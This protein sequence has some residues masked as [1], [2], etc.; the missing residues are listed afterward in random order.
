MNRVRKL[1]AASL[2][3]G[4]VTLFAQSV[5]PAET[6]TYTYDALGRL[7]GSTQDSGTPSDPS[8]DITTEYQYDAAGN[9]THYELTGTGTPAPPGAVIVVPLNGYTIIPIY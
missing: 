7:T 6:T 5:D 4:A 1:F 8:D 9:R 2:V 3:S